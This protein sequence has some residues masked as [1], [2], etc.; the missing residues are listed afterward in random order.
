MYALF[1]VVPGC[2]EGK[3]RSSEG[4]KPEGMSQGS[5]E[6]AA[7]MKVAVIGWR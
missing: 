6:S 4:R 3:R 7:L 1:S 5:L 2:L